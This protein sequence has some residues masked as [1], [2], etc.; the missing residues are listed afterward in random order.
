MEKSS[1]NPAFSSSALAAALLGQS[2]TPLN[3]LLGMLGASLIGKSTLETL[4]MLEE[5]NENLAIHLFWENYDEVIDSSRKINHLID[6][7]ISENKKILQTE[8]NK[9]I[10]NFLRDH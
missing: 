3:G 1:K 7:L 10:G 5:E 6:R 4:E 9:A 8:K 2:P